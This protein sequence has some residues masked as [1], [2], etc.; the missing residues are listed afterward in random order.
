MT[1]DLCRRAGTAFR[2]RHA[3]ASS[4]RRLSGR[5]R[6]E[7]VAFAAIIP[8]ITLALHTIGF[9]RTQAALAASIRRRPA[10]RTDARDV[11]VRGLQRARRYAPYRGNCLPQSLAL[12]W[13][14]RRQGLQAEFCLGARLDAGEL[15]AHAWVEA[16]GRA[17]NDSPTVRDRFAAFESLGSSRP[18]N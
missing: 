6:R 10:G 8:I 9:R 18:A 17:L 14:L 15:A 16:D 3:L 12:W 2:R 13:R 11:A 5:E 7:F 1:I 4:W